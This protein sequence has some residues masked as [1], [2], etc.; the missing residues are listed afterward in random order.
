MRQGNGA[1]SPLRIWLCWRLEPTPGVAAGWK[2]RR[3]CDLRAGDVGVARRS[4]AV[5][6]AFGVL[7]ALSAI[8]LRT[9]C[10][11]RPSHAGVFGRAFVSID[12][13]LSRR[14]PKPESA[15]KR[16]GR[17]HADAGQTTVRPPRCASRQ[18]GSAVELGSRSRPCHLR[19]RRW[20]VQAK[21]AAKTVLQRAH[22]ACTAATQQRFG[23]RYNW[24]QFS[25]ANHGLKPV[26][27]APHFS[28]YPRL[29]A[30]HPARCLARLG[31]IDHAR[32]GR[33]VMHKGLI[34]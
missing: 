10:A 9:V 23:D 5:A 22:F 11:V 28:H 19:V 3:A 33:R 18:I 17:H 26:I 34:H 24:H 7:P 21:A 6:A 29:V 25:V 16:T 31:R 30:H 4:F 13:P 8:L 15:P 1:G 12:W 14:A 27:H 32:T 2:H 20:R